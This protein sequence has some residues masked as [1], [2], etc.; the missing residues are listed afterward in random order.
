MAH[1]QGCE[2][3]VPLKAFVGGG[4]GALMSGEQKNRRIWKPETKRFLWL[5]AWE[6]SQEMEVS[7]RVALGAWASRKLSKFPSEIHLVIIRID[8]LQL[9]IL[10]IF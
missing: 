8:L 3:L 5:G 6:A 9:N 4:A 7:G 2:S 10:N 1:Q